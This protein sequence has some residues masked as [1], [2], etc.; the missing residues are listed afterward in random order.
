[1]LISLA[2]SSPFVYA[3]ASLWT[4]TTVAG[5]GTCTEADG[6]STSALLNSPF[7]IAIDSQNNSKCL[8]Y[9]LAHNPTSLLH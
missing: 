2:I 9:D 7:G 6:Q 3:Q 1:M 4:V 5:N 8:I